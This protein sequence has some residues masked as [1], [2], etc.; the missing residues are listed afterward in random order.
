MTLNTVRR[1]SRLSVDVDYEAEALRKSECPERAL[2]TA[3]LQRAILDLQSRV[4]HISRET[5][6][7]FTR[8]YYPKDYIGISFKQ[9]MDELNFSKEGIRLIKAS[10]ER[11]IYDKC[12]S[13]RQK[14]GAR[15]S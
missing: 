8:T 11:A 10:V 4:P 1:V 14:S 13:K 2:L 3:V 9:I 6:E 7:W 15:F 5:I 12:M